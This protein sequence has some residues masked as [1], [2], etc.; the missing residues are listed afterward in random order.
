MKALVTTSFL[1][2]DEEN[3]AGDFFPKGKEISTN[4]A[5]QAVEDGLAEWITPPTTAEISNKPKRQTL[6][7]YIEVPPKG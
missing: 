4:V 3:P 1:G 2:A 7:P 6:Q 5:H